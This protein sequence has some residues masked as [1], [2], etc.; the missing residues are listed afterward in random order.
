MNLK[1]MKAME[2]LKKAVSYIEQAHDEAQAR[3][4][5]YGEYF[6][7]GRQYEIMLETTIL[8]KDIKNFLHT[9]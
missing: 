8:L 9:K 5:N 2:L 1:E 7:D 3:H 4:E 6:M